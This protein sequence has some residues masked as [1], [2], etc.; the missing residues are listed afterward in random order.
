MAL[1]SSSLKRGDI[2]L[3][4]NFMKTIS[5]ATAST[6]G[7]MRDNTMRGNGLLANITVWACS[8]KM[9][10]FAMR[11]SSRMGG[12]MEMALANIRMATCM[13][14]SGKI[15]PKVETE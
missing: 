12:L 8:S 11:G 13:W 6:F 5:M 1:V 14:G 9:A 7:R 4:A 2:D 15:M 3:R 10:V